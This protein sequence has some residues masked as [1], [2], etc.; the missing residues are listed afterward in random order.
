MLGNLKYLWD[1]EYNQMTEECL[2]LKLFPFF[3][4]EKKIKAWL[5]SLPPGSIYTW[6]GIVEALYRKF[7]S[8]QKTTS[9]RQAL[10][11]FHQQKWEKFFTYFER[12]KDLLPECLN[13]GFEK[14]RLIQILYEGL[15]SQNKTMI[16]SF[17]NGTFTSKTVDDAWQFFLKR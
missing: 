16:E 7:Y 17:C 3:L 15:D 14:I 11:T 6:V 9:V 1:H 10:N 4:K 12:F 8:K 2:K 13:H 5:F